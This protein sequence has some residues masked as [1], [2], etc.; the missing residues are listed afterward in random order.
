MYTKTLPKKTNLLLKKIKDYEFLPS[1]YLS[2]GTALALQLGHRESEDLDFFNQKSFEPLK[3]QQA[4]EEI[5]QLEEV[6][7]A[8]GTLNLYL[9][10]VPLQFLYYPYQLL[11]S[12]IRWQGINLSSVLDIACTKLQTISSRG[13]KKDFIDL[14]VILKDYSLKT[15]LLCM[16]KKYKGVDYNWPHILKSLV[17]FKEAERQPMPKMHQKIE[18]EEVKKGIIETVKN[19]RF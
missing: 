15:L 11:K 2:G 10:G 6:Q 13:A 1:F 8:E 7:I 17:Y 19:F 9:K 16:E 12:L 18:W 4:L 5:G 3:I 14:Y